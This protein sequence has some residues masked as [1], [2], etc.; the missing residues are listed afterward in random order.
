MDSTSKFEIF[1]SNLFDSIIF[2]NEIISTILFVVMQ[3]M[4][5]LKIKI[6]KTTN[7]DI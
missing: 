5:E 2:Q 3:K 7:L 1:F 6:D 4:S